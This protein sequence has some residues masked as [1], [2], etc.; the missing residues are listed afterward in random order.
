MRGD[1]AFSGRGECPTCGFWHKDERSARVRELLNDGIATAKAEQAKQD[2]KRA[3]TPGADGLGRAKQQALATA[4][5]NEWPLIQKYDAVFSV[6][7][8]K[9]DDLERAG[10]EMFRDWHYLC[11]AA[12]L[13]LVIRPDPENVIDSLEKEIK[14]VDEEKACWQIAIEQLSG[15]SAHERRT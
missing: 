14:H 8:A 2:A 12:A 3:A 10:G 13:E 4:L 15:G 5:Q 1:P 7:V 11:R 9:M 6:R